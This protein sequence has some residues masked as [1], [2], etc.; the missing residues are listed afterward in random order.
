MYAAKKRG[1]RRW[2][3]ADVSLHAAAMR[4]L[5]VEA[6]LRRALERNE[7]R[8]HYQPLVDLAT[9][10]IV[11]VEALVRWQHPHRGLVLPG[12]FVDVAEQRGLIQGMGRWILQTA[13]EQAATWYHHYGGRAPRIAVNV[14]SRQLG[15]HGMKTH[16]THALDVHCLPADRLS[17]E[18]TENHLVAAGT[19]S[20]TDLRALAER[21][22]RIAVDDFGTGYAG[23]DYLRRLPIDELKIDKSFIDGLGIDSTSTAI[24]ASVVTLGR[25]L[26]LTVVAEG[27]QTPEQKQTLRDMGCSWGQG[28]LWHPALTA[29]DL[30]AIL[31]A[32][33]S[34]PTQ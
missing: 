15:N 28:W 8:V 18:V 4:V 6:E 19:S 21:G 5:T 7:L 3:P 32:G 27:V 20:T 24:T 9:E 12:D 16:V 33:A 13:C 29:E 11:A 34:A 17:L 10:A 14:S 31:A 2:E 22:V 1:G 26:G 30:D 23:F 25:T